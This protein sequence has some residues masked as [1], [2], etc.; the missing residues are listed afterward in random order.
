M[1]QST[2]R[3]DEMRP[4]NVNEGLQK[5]KFI[6]TKIDQQKLIGNFTALKD[7]TVEGV[8]ELQGILGGTGSTLHAQKKLDSEYER[9]ANCPN[10]RTTQ[11]ENQLNKGPL[12]S[13][14][15]AP[16]TQDTTYITGDKEIFSQI[17]GQP[18]GIVDKYNPTLSNGYIVNDSYNNISANESCQ[19][20]FIQFGNVNDATT[21]LS[22][23]GEVTH[24]NMRTIENKNTDQLI[25]LPTNTVTKAQPHATAGG[26]I[27]QTITLSQ[28]SQINPTPGGTQ[29][30]T[31]SNQPLR[32]DSH[33]YTKASR[34]VYENDP[35]D[36]PGV[37]TGISQLKSTDLDQIGDTY[38][39]STRG[40][41][42]S[43][44]IDLIGPA[45]AYNKQSIVGSLEGKFAVQDIVS[46]SKEAINVQLE[47]RNPTQMGSHNPINTT[48]DPN[49]A[50][51]QP[52]L[53]ESTPQMSRVYT[54]I[55]NENQLG[56]VINNVSDNPS[57]FFN[58]EFDETVLAK[59][60]QIH[61]NP[62]N[63]DINNT[64]K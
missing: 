6:E 57:S 7:K 40:G 28:R 53:Q 18:T 38:T 46:Y 13:I 16:T 47:K 63:I 58:D 2:N 43:A 44:S 39:L 27:D 54:E 30:I 32:I 56:H 60:K 12:G 26:V 19:S 36:A 61:N 51:N 10:T 45:N 14:V 31:G 11:S 48:V 21:S 59:N 55:S 20:G 4:P 17:V 37:P 35:T 1:G 50:L 42:Q 52:L 9:L 3:R 62:W 22:Q 41:S 15:N 24:L 8:S 29:S 33:N 34:S 5:S 25:G 49:M 64:N 23:F